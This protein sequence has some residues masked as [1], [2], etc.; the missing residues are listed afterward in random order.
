MQHSNSHTRSTLFK[1]WKMLKV[2]ITQ[3]AEEQ[4]GVSRAVNTGRHS[5]T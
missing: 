4:T 5:F 1:V 3:E 2:V